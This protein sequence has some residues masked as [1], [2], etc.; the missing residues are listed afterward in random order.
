MR[1]LRKKIKS[2]NWHANED[3]IYGGKLWNIVAPMLA[4][5]TEIVGAVVYAEAS[6][7]ISPAPS[8]VPCL[9]RLAG[10]LVS[11]SSTGTERVYAYPSAR[12]DIFALPFQES[13]S[14]SLESLSH[15]RNLQFFKNLMNVPFF[16]LEH[17][18]E[19]HT[20]F[21][22]ENPS[23]EWT[24]STMVQEPYVNHIPTISARNKTLPRCD[25]N[26]RKTKFHLHS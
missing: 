16:D 1:R 17:I 12:S 11:S 7:V 10:E 9:K 4:S 23:V 3:L 24:M 2:L 6:E 20:Y 5:V 18:W 25:Y 22:F 26:R 13:F 15:T 21:E 8:S 14:Y 19:E